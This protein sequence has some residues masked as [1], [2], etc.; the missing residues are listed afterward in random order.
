MCQTEPCYQCPCPNSWWRCYQIEITQTRALES[1]H[2]CPKFL[3]LIANL[4][5]AV[6]Q[7]KC[8]QNYVFCSFSM[9]SKRI[10]GKIPH[11]CARL[12]TWKNRW[13]KPVELITAWRRLHI[14]CTCKASPHCEYVHTCEGLMMSWTMLYKPCTRKASPRCEFVCVLADRLNERSI[15]CIHHTWTEVDVQISD[16]FW[17][18]TH[19]SII[20]VT[21][22]NFCPKFFLLIA[23]L[24][25]AA[26]GNNCEK[27][28]CCCSFLKRS[29]RI[30]GTIPHSCARGRTIEYNL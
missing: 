19:I 24:S 5:T 20:R 7:N 30:V 17:T 18:P 23:I 28:Y 12:R 29:K 13:I 25:T 21:W 26:E 11:A 27:S 9:D 1:Y 4:S 2:S 14:P 3:L 8:K 15:C 10:V 6:E 16:L 22:Y